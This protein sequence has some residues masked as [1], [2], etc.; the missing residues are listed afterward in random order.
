MAARDTSVTGGEPTVVD[1][2]MQAK[3]RKMIFRLSG[4]LKQRDCESICYLANLPTQEHSSKANLPLHILGSL[5]ANGHISPRNVEELESLLSE[6]NRKELLPVVSGYKE[7]K[8]YKNALKKKKKVKKSSDK[9]CISDCATDGLEKKPADEKQRLRS[10]YALLI[11]HITALTQVMEILREELD[12]TG[13]EAV[14]QAMERFRQVAEDG[15]NFTGNLRKVFKDMG[16]KSNR[17][18]LSDD[19]TSAATPNAGESRCLKGGSS[20][21]SNDLMGVAWGEG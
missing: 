5:E 7:S 9:S 8:E 11:T 14:E 4:M 15:E 10:L 21:E 6:I 3:F 13:D 2:Q 1:K 17:S 18:S 16:I 19:D 12:K 20:E